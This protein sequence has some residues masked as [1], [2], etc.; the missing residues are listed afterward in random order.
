MIIQVLHVIEIYHDNYI[1]LDDNFEY[2]YEGYPIVPCDNYNWKDIHGISH[3]MEYRDN[4]PPT[5][6]INNNIIT[7]IW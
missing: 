3:Y 2:N 5:F 4:M 6:T 7:Y 1:Q